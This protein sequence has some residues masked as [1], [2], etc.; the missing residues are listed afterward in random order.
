[1]T[2]LSRAMA[3]E[4]ELK[5]LRAGFRALAP[6]VQDDLLHA[7]RWITASRDP[8]ILSVLTENGRVF[9]ALHLE[10]VIRR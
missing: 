5:E 9:G 7:V 3:L 4:P 6:E 2:I 1:M 8:K 10:A